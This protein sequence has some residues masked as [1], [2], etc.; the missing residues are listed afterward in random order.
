MPG[1]DIVNAFE[2]FADGPRIHEFLAEMTGEVF[3]DATASS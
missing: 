2:Q 1:Q 3:G